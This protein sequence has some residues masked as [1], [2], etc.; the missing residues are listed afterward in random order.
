MKKLYNWS[1]LSLVIIFI[2]FTSFIISQSILHPDGYITSDSA[3]YLQMSKNFL[4]GDGMSTV[5]FIP[6]MSTYQAT[7][8]VGYP[9]LIAGVSFVTGLS[10]FWASKVVNILVFALCLLLL[11][12]LFKE[13]A[14]IVAMV[15]F[16]STF[17]T[18][19][20]YTW[21][22]VPFFL[23]LIWLVFGIVRYVETNR[24]RYA[25]HM[26]LAAMFL[27]FM[28]Y[29]G[30]IGAGI[31]G[32]VGFYYLFR[33]K[34]REML[35]CWIAG[36]IPILVAGLYLVKNYIETGLMTGME[37]I[38]RAESTPE[39][40]RMVYRGIRGEINIL[41]TSSQVYFTESL[42]LIVVAIVLFVRPKHIAA[43]FQLPKE[44]LLLPGMFL[45]AGIVYTLAIVYMRWNS[46]FDP[47]NF[48]LLA[49]A[50][51]MFW[52]FIISWFAQLDKESWKRW[53][54]SLLVMFSVA[55]LMNVGYKTYTSALSPS[56]DYQDT[57][58][59][60]EAM[61]EEIPSGSI[62]AFE[63]IHARYLRPDLQYVKVHFR[64]YFATKE[65]VDEF[66]GRVTPNSAAG[67]FLQVKSISESR[68]HESF[69]ELMESA[70]ETDNFTKLK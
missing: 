3:H 62:V 1:N 42:L 57:I 39:F 44:K 34:W 30:L 69:V 46:H 52:L 6:D 14:S 58:A 54:N 16:I 26:S 27:F 68:Y 20:A 50:T 22:E 35:T 24:Y 18:D 10:V 64:P 40:I 70:P 9:V 63:N 55:L 60:V 13:K 65:T 31:V 19:F 12:R 59:E 61:Y 5:N 7:W 2:I 4:A 32:L 29:I 38:P 41:S 45:F 49:P 56:A 47:L 21:S 66:L 25:V 36:T 67:V 53:R 15:F 48:R 37:R 33:K 43:L 11:Q 28:R 17:T 8:P 51:L 23:G